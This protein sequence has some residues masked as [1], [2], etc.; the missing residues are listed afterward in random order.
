LFRDRFLCYIRGGQPLGSSRRYFGCN[1]KTLPKGDIAFKF[2]HG[3]YFAGESLSWE[4]KAIAFVSETPG[5]ETTLARIFLI[6]FDQFD[7]VLQQERGIAHPLVNH[8]CPELDYIVDHG[9]CFANLDPTVPSDK[10]MSTRY[11]RLIYLGAKWGFPIVTFTALAPA[12]SIT[13][14]EPSAAYLQAI[15]RGIREV[16][17]DATL[18]ELCEYFLG[19]DG[20]VGNIQPQQL[21]NWLG[22]A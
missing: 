15:S 7:Q 13:K 22:Q 9:M 18:D 10:K 20:I 17:P 11:E 12:D 21:R 16:F 14:R 8:I 1:D 5:E 4:K 2:K 6:R 3:L 19:K